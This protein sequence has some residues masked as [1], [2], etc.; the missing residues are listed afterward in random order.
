MMALIAMW[1]LGL[2]LAAIACEDFPY[3]YR[4][5]KHVVIVLWPLLGLVL[6]IYVIFIGVKGK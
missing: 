4:W 6:W 1:F 5:T 3:Q 2:P